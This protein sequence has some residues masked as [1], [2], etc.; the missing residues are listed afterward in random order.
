[1]WK[2]EPLARRAI[3][4]NEENKNKNHM[5]I[6]G[7]KKLR[8]LFHFFF[9]RSSPT[10][11]LAVYLLL[12]LHKCL[13][14]FSTAQNEIPRMFGI[15]SLSSFQMFAKW[16]CF[17]FRGFSKKKSGQWEKFVQIFSRQGT[18]PHE[19]KNQTAE[20]LCFIRRYLKYFMINRLF[21]SPKNTVL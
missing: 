7:M 20:N 15:R 3:A 6:D 9:P 19:R 1:M 10:V 2:Y 17:Y 5:Q 21:C 8:V 13:K 11:C 4:K 16:K 18:Q 12:L 14:L